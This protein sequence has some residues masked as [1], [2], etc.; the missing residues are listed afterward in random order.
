MIY[1]VTSVNLRGTLWVRLAIQRKS[2][3]KFNLCP[4]ATT[5][6][7]VWPRLKKVHIFG[8]CTAFVSYSQPI[9]F[10]RLDSEHAHSDW[11]FGLDS[12]TFSVGPSQ[13]SRFLVLTKR[14]VSSADDRE[15][16]CQ[17][18]IMP[19]ARVRASFAFQAGVPIQLIKILWYHP[20]LYYAS[21]T[22]RLQSIRVIGNLILNNTPS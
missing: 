17:P 3:R 13:R 15:W 11:K 9:I 20:P 8:S 4:L 5:C 10:V 14:S 16:A 7:S 6:R 21:T 2:L 12:R 18:K 1:F 22:Y 19:F